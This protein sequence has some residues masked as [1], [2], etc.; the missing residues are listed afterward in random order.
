MLRLHFHFFVTE[1]NLKKL[2]KFKSRLMST[3]EGQL[4]AFV[5]LNK[6]VRS[7]IFILKLIPEYTDEEY[8]VFVRADRKADIFLGKYCMCP[9]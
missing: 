4:D 6:V 3:K 9:K 7:T 5:P 1:I 2:V 8:N